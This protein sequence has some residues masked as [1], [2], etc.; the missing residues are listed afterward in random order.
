MCE[1]LIL[2]YENGTAAD[3]K[4]QCGFQTLFLIFLTPC[5]YMHIMLSG[6]IKDARFQ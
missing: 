6:H 2:T 4:A 1:I 5:F 3:R